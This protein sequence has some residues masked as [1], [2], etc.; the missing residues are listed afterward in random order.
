MYRGGVSMYV[1]MYVYVGIYVCRCVGKVCPGR[2]AYP[3]PDVACVRRAYKSS[4]T[5]PDT[6]SQRLLAES[7]TNPP[8]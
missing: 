4:L 6:S 8:G 5:Q 7:C 1:C 3:I 2:C